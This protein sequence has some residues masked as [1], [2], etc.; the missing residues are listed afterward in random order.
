MLP[1]DILV[2]ILQCLDRYILDAVQ[3][4]SKELRDILTEHLLSVCLRRYFKVSVEGYQVGP[5][6]VTIDATNGKNWTFK[7]DREEAVQTLTKLMP[8]TVTDLLYINGL[9]D[10]ALCHS[11]T[12]MTSDAESAPQVLHLHMFD[13]DVL[14]EEEGLF[15]RAVLSLPCMQSLVCEMVASCDEG[16]RTMAMD[17]EFI[18]KC[19]DKGVREFSFDEWHVDF[20]H[21]A[22]FDFV[23]HATPGNAERKFSVN[24]V[25]P[26]K[27]FVQRIIPCCI[28]ISGVSTLAAKDGTLAPRFL[29]KFTSVVELSE[30]DT[31]HLV[32][33]E[34][35]DQ[36]TTELLHPET[37]VTVC[38][39][40]PD[41]TIARF[42]E[43]IIKRGA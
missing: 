31:K 18:R 9:M 38:Y 4:S 26:P 12:R 15:A 35:A 32:S 17:A 7:G 8:R 16:R 23:T 25:T 11:V 42:A 22:I 3:I 28:A 1:T 13:T 30:L 10:T 19:I 14:I 41:N 40:P 43:V 6:T 5:T 33:S 29:L 2:D 21:D 36:G 34:K 24:C 27:D 39:T 20:D 37:S